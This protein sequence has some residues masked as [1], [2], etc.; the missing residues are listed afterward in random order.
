[1]FCAFVNTKTALILFK[2]NSGMPEDY[3]ILQGIYLLSI[4]LTC[5]CKFK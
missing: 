4:P 2:L 1:M 3:F 5:I